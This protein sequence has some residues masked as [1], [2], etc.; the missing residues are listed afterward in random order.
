MSS[1]EGAST[2]TD[3]IDEASGL[4]RVDDI[5]LSGNGSGHTTRQTSVLEDVDEFG[6][7][8]GDSAH[9]CAEHTTMDSSS[10][11]AAET[12]ALPM[13]SALARDLPHS[14]A[15]WRAP[16]HPLAPLP[17]SLGAQLDTKPP[18]YNDFNSGCT[19]EMGTQIGATCGNFAVNHLIEG[20]ATAGVG[21]R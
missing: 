16:R 17:S 13:T 12:S 1:S 2:E 15:P 5:P 19:N 7:L 3:Y 21:V 11:Y 20:A 10:L 4:N 6:R 18:W 9:S 14:S 8:V